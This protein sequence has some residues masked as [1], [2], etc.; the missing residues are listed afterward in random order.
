MFVIVEFCPFG[1]L[2]KYIESKREKFIDQINPSTSKFDDSYPPDIA[3]LLKPDRYIV[4]S[5]CYNF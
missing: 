3:S 1:N 2:Q 4:I 5:Y